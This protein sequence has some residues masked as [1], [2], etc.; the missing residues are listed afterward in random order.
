MAN[1]L[2]LRRRIR[3]VKN[4]RQITRAM[5][6]V[7]AAKLRRA[8]ERAITSRPYAAMLASVLESLK[9]RIEIVDPDT[10]E[11]RHPLLKTREEKRIL[12]VVVSG[13]KGFAGGFN[14][15]IIKATTHFLGSNDGKE[16]DVEAIGRKGRDLFRRRYPAARFQEIESH[17]GHA[18]RPERQRSSQIE[19][20]GD[21]PGLLE[22]LSFDAAREL[23]EEIVDRYVH[24]EIDAVYIVYNEFK[25]VIQQ[26]VVVER[27]LPIIEFGR[28]EITESQEM[29]AEERARAAEAAL[30]AGVSL[31]PGEA[32]ADIQEFE[33][34]A[35]KFGTAE[36]DY[37]YE[38]KPREIFDAI[39]PRYVTSQIYH[40]L[41]ES[42][43]AEHAARMTAMDSATNNAGE[44]IDSLTLTMNRVRQAAITREIIEIVSGA[45]AL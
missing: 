29:S 37:I 40:A 16:I 11:V 44:I 30:T 10:G 27:I 36:V 42:V 21:H 2:D 43:A 38:Q 17:D 9:R 13:D 45:A 3:S 33:D 26:R 20:I 41:L 8:Q 19:V 6:M 15:N 22:K 23:G 28:H 1:V 31:Q 12:L 18:P 35:K 4:T 25:S 5:K 39:L 32:E 24:E 34:E 7:S 14:T